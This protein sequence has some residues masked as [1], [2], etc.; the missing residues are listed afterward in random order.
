MPHFSDV[1]IAGH[2][3]NIGLLGAVL[4]VL[5]VWIIAYLAYRI[6]WR[7]D[8]GLPVRRRLLATRLNVE[9]DQVAFVPLWWSDLQIQRAVSSHWKQTLRSTAARAAATEPPDS[10][11]GTGRA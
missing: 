4:A 6:F 8:F 7:A 3:V 2:N 5:L 11:A 1:D 10:R 9:R